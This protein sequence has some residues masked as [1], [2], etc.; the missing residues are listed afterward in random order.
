MA[1]GTIPVELRSAIGG[2]DP[3]LRHPPEGAWPADEKRRYFIQFK[4][5]LLREERQEIQANY[6]LLLETYVP[7]YIY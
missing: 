6:G 1:D 2:P 7:K 5:S 4:H 3:R